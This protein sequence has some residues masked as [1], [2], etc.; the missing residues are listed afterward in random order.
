M[1]SELL[2]PMVSARV[3]GWVRVR[4]SDQTKGRRSDLR[5]SKGRAWGFEVQFASCRHAVGVEGETAYSRSWP[6]PLEMPGSEAV[7]VCTPAARPSTHPVQH[8]LLLNGQLWGK[9]GGC[10]G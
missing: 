2:F 4:A 8:C 1:T 10:S 5:D 7:V 9:V 6:S 3:G